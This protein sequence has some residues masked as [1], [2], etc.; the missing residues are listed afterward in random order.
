MPPV[1]KVT[2]DLAYP[3]SEVTADHLEYM[4]GVHDGFQPSI[5]EGPD[6]RTLVHL[7]IPSKTEQW[8]TMLG[9]KL[10][11][12]STPQLRGPILDIT[13]ALATESDFTPP[14]P[15]GNN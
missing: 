5:T 9:E 3:Y 2:A 1:Y 8:A 10:I 12:S 14:T 7:F 4:E 15:P 13:A 6:G 11:T